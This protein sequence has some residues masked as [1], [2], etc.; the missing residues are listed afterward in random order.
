MCLFV[1]F[2]VTASVSVS[3]Y[4]QKWHF[5]EAGV[6][7]A[8]AV[9]GFERMVDG[10]ANRPFVYRQLLPAIANKLERVTPDRVKGWAFAHQG[11]GLNSY[12]LS[13]S[14]SPT[15]QIPTY[16]FRYQVIYLLGAC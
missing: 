3:G 6:L 13:I 2:F 12:L 1:L 4:Y 15:A 11:K 9:A 5:L 7:G 10:T 14:Y 8:Y 16:L